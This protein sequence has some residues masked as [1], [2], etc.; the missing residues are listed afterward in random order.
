MVL[1]WLGHLL[2]PIGAS[3]FPA[4]P[5]LVFA[6]ILNGQFGIMLYAEKFLNINSYHL[7]NIQSERRKWGM[8]A[9]VN[10]THW[11]TDQT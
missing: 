10:A 5:H 11:L 9:N 3:V 6:K 2:H 8:S 1:L 4:K 7:C